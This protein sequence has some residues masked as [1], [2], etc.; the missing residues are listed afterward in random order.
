MA[1]Q[2]TGGMTAKEREQVA[3][4]LHHLAAAGLGLQVA[5]VQQTILGAFP[6]FLA[7]SWDVC[8]HSRCLWGRRSVYGIAIGFGQLC[9]DLRFKTA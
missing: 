6:A 9:L 3:A 4:E 7:S 1:Q 8:M 2:Q 5:P